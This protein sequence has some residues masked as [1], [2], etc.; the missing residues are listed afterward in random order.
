MQ[1]KNIKTEQII[2]YIFFLAIFL[3][4]INIYSDYGLTLDDEVY[5]KN[6][7][8]YFEYIKIIFLGDNSDVLSKNIEDLSKELSGELNPFNAPVLFELPLVFITKILNINNSKE[9]YEH[10]HLFNFIIFFIALIFFFRFIDKKFNSTFYSLLSIVVLCFSPRIFAESFYNS[11]DIFFLSLFI[12]Y[13]YAANNFLFKQN[14]KTVIYFSITSAWIIYAKVVGVVP[15]VLFIFFYYLNSMKKNN[16]NLREFKIIFFIIV[17]I[18]LFI[19]IFWPYL[20]SDPINNLLHSFKWM[21]DAQNDH[22]VINYYFGQ[23]ISSTNTPWHY[24]VVFFLISTPISVLF[25]FIIGLILT[26]IQI[27]NGFIKINEVRT[28]PWINKDELINFYLF[29]V[30]VIVT[31]ASIKFSP[32]QFCSWRHIY[33]LYP[34]VIFYFLIG[35]KFLVSL[36]KNVKYKNSFFLLII[37]NFIYIFYWNYTYHPNQQV[38]FNYI[39]KDYAKKNFDLDY[40]GLS[41]LYSI[42]YI[43]ENNHKYPIKMAT[44]SFSKLDDSVLMLEESV[45][46]SVFVCIFAAVSV[47]DFIK[48]PTASAC[49]ISIFPLINAL[50]VNSP[51]SA[52]LAPFS[53]MSS[54]IISTKD[55]LPWHDISTKS[56]PVY[57]FGF[58]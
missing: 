43:L 18:V 8:F 31:F 30:I 17:L 6:G 11:R 12:F 47:L 7:E 33:F 37:I 28:D 41:N 1:F 42:K 13:L 25:F 52:S 38:F 57:D 44:I 29:S 23:H 45:P 34:I 55:G 50:L 2:I 19:Y 40:W 35:L 48:A 5:L 54:I 46:F 22:V 36:F 53:N 3:L 39:S 10:T 16:S 20:W 49:S 24:R 21:I 26:F 15:V 14:F 51:G 9:I 32:S 56:S 27:V 4:G 58:L